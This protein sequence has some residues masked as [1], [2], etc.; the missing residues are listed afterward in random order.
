MK[1]FKGI[2]IMFGLA[3][4]GISLWRLGFDGHI[5]GLYGGEPTKDCSFN[6]VITAGGHPTN[7]ASLNSKH[8][9]YN[10]EECDVISEHIQPCHIEFLDT[11]RNPIHLMISVT[12]SS[13]LKFIIKDVNSAE[14]YSVKPEHTNGQLEAEVT[15]ESWFIT[16]KVNRA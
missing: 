3:L 15:T 11:N 5:L 13:P 9:T 16:I 7:P 8:W 14:N 4:A 10:N 2:F 6:I 12:D 1:E